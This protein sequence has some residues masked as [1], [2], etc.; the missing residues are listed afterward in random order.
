MNIIKHY[1]LLKTKNVLMDDE[2]EMVS[3]AGVAEPIIDE[4]LLIISGLSQERKTQRNT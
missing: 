1:K 2:L 4:T 3:A